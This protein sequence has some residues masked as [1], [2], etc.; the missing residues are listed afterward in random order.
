MFFI[1]PG[2]N[3]DMQYVYDIR[4]CYKIYKDQ[5]E[6]NNILTNVCSQ[7]WLI[8]RILFM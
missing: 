7:R 3:E 5:N 6:Q 4:P 1:L 8:M 2:K